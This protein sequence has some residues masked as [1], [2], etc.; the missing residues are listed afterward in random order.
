MDCVITKTTAAAK[1]IYDAT[2]GGQQ[3][4]ALD[5]VYVPPGNRYTFCV[6][7]DLFK[8]KLK[9]F[10]DNKM[11]SLTVGFLQ[12]KGVFVYL[13]ATSYISVLRLVPE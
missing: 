1:R 11:L 3:V 8:I 6:C 2:Q 7:G 4:M 9:V 12:F 5:S 10:C 13:Q